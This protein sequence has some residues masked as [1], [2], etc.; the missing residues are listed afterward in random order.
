MIL[1]RQKRSNCDNLAT[2]KPFSKGKKQCSSIP[3]QLNIKGTIRVLKDM[4][5]KRL[6]FHL[7]EWL[8]KKD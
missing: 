7:K 5:K 3:N 6:N 2:E 4:T 1:I 8:Y